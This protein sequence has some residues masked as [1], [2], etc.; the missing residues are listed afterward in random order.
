MPAD[1]SLGST[2]QRGVEPGGGG[3]ASGLWSPSMRADRR[4]GWERQ[5]SVCR[6][7]DHNCAKL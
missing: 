3:P 2:G 5:T 4:A 7:K 6:V 1:L